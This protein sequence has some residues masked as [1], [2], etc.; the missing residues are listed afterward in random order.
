MNPGQASGRPSGDGPG[1]AGSPASERAC[2]GR[3]PAHP[4]P[5][6]ERVTAQPSPQDRQTAQRGPRRA[7]RGAL[8][9]A[10]G[11]HGGAMLRG[12]RYAH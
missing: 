9:K 3:P 5:V 10:D 12:L 7:G 2:P 4:A 6:G 11:G 8:G 1:R